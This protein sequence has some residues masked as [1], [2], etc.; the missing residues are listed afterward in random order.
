MKLRTLI[1][2]IVF[3]AILAASAGVFLYIGLQT[4]PGSSNEF[5]LVATGQAYDLNNKK[6]VSVTFS[7]NGTL[8]EDGVSSKLA[9]K[10]G[11]FKID[12]YQTVSIISGEATLKPENSSSLEISMNLLVLNSQTSE[13]WNFSGKTDSMLTS[14]TP[15]RLFTDETV[16][17]FQG[18]PSIENLALFGQMTINKQVAS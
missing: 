2:V 6:T 1:V 11:N 3:I 9:I 13:S 8:N 17:P 5:S 18:S 7:I 10:S 15:V 4:N 14:Q 12:G 16:L